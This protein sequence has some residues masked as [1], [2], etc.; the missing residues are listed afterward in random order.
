[1]SPDREKISSY[2]L[3]IK[4]YDLGTKRRE[5]TRVYT[6]NVKDL[7]DNRPE[8]NES[9]YTATVKE[10]TKLSTKIIQVTAEDPDA[11]ENGK[12]YFSLDHH[13]TFELLNR[14]VILKKRLDYATKSNYKLKVIVKD[15]G[16]ESKTGFC[17]LN[18][19]VEDVNEYKPKFDRTSYTAY[20]DENK[21]I[22]TSV[23][24]VHAT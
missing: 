1:M 21:P 5:A 12:M 13:D 18:I 14:W 7:N 24:A 20:L 6:I 17:A 4:A 16:K 8:C 9:V 22:G 23:L 11:G 10:N 15:G 3:T 19:K 2:D